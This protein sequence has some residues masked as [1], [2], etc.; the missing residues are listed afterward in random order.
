MNII[1]YCEGGIFIFRPTT[2]SIFWRRY[3][4]C[5][6]HKIKYALLLYCIYIAASEA[7]QSEKLYV[8]TSRRHLTEKDKALNELEELRSHLAAV[9]AQVKCRE[10]SN[11]YIITNLPNLV[12][13]QLRKQI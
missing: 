13:S 3:F 6:W 9:R 8:P 5:F 11:R 4:R 7:E 12:K 1:T 10:E 2:F